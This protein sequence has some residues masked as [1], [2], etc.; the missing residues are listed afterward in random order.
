MLGTV[1]LRATSASAPAS[2]A[3]PTDASKWTLQICAS[4][5]LFASLC[6]AAVFST[7]WCGVLRLL[8]LPVPRCLPRRRVWPV[9]PALAWLASARGAVGGT[10]FSCSGPLASAFFFS[11]CRCQ[12][13]GSRWLCGSLG[14]PHSVSNFSRQGYRSCRAA[15][16]ASVSLSATGAGS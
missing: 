5:P 6:T 16:S 3:F 11:S 7:L 1:S 12:P 4:A 2:R 8:T 13:A 15:L 9:F 10:I 14:A